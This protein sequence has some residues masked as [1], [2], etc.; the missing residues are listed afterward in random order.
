MM[1]KM[2]LIILIFSSLLFLS[3]CNASECIDL[4]NKISNGQ[5][6]TYEEKRN[7]NKYLIPDASN[8]LDSKSNCYRNLLAI[9]LY[10][11]KYLKQDKVLAEKIF[12]EVGN[13]GYPEG[14]FNFAMA[15]SKRDDQ[16][17]EDILQLM[18]GVYWSNINKDTSYLSEKMRVLIIN[19]LD[20][21]EDKLVKQ[22]AE[23]AMKT[24]H[25]TIAEANNP[26]QV[27]YIKDNTW[28]IIMA[29]VSVGAIAYGLSSAS[30]YSSGGQAASSTT[31]NPWINWGQGFGNP[32]NLPQIPL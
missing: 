10:K 1:K 32:L 18:L 16:K 9:L 24:N 4:K 11:G 6:L 23:T 25:E 19:Y 3:V 31:P 22:R 12:Y 2:P 26:G 5:D 17:Q 28:D 8:H 14:L 15:M 21:V 7:I 13:N 29:V 27:R 30:G 20:K